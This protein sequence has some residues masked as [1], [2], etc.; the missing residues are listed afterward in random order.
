M[1]AVASATAAQAAAGGDK[2]KR[3]ITPTIVTQ[4]L[5][6]DVAGAS[7]E[8]FRAEPAAVAAVAVEAMEAVEAVEAAAGL[9]SGVS[10]GRAVAAAEPAG[11]AGKEVTASAEGLCDASADQKENAA[12]N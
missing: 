3:R 11:L 7:A 6:L 5:P 1:A 4:C 2:K 8:A 12:V 10:E 9:E